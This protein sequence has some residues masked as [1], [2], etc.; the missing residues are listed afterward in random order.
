[1]LVRIGG[2]H[3]DRIAVVGDTI[4]VAH[5]DTTLECLMRI[6]IA[7]ARA[8]EGVE[9][10]VS[11]QC[12]V[13]GG[14]KCRDGPAKTMADTM[15]DVGSQDRALFAL[16]LRQD[17]SERVG[18]ALVDATEIAE[19]SMRKA[20]I[21]AE[22]IPAQFGTRAAHGDDRVVLPAA[23]EVQDVTETRHRIPTGAASEYPAK[24]RAGKVP[25]HGAVRWKSTVR[26]ARAEYEVLHPA[27]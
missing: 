19:T 13:V 25:A 21:S 26:V 10:H 20:K 14:R 1:M 11:V 8:A 27:S 16:Q 2:N 23:L 3:R 7:D 4:D 6:A 24:L 18:K 5:A 22:V 12:G 15:D 9:P 17:A